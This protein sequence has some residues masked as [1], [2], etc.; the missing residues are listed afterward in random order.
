MGVNK[1][2]FGIYDTQ[3]VHPNDCLNHER[4]SIHSITESVC[5]GSVVCIGV[6]SLMSHM[7]QY[8]KVQTL[9]ITP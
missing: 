1:H 3:H 2:V 6:C 8:M 7:H 4:I 5:E 9:A